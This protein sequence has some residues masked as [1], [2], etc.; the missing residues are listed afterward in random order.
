MKAKPTLKTD[1]LLVRQ[2]EAE[3]DSKATTELDEKITKL[4]ITVQVET[5]VKMGADSG[6]PGGCI[7]EELQPALKV[8]K[9]GGVNLNLNIVMRM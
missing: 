4:K 2:S 7:I 5:L 9:R 3:E 8:I 1:S 6:N